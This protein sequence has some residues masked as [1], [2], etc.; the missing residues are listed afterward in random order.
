MLRTDKAKIMRRSIATAVL[1]W[2][3]PGLAHG[4]APSAAQLDA[5]YV[6]SGLAALVAQIP[7]GIQ[8]GFDRYYRQES[9]GS[10]SAPQYK[11]IRERIPR[12]FA[13]EAMRPRIEAVLAERLATADAKT[14]L[15]WFDSPLGR[16]ATALESAAAGPEALEAMQAYARGL[17]QSPPSAE[18]MKRLGALAAA[19]K[20]VDNAVAV[21]MNTQLAV[22]G[23]M[24]AMMPDAQQKSFEEIRARL[25]ALRPQI[26]AAMENQTIIAFLYTYRDL[27]ASDLDAYVRFARSEAG[28]RYHAAAAAGIQQAL[29]AGS[30]ALGSAIAEIIEATEP[31][32]DI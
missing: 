2:L 23:G 10:L 7:A 5:L 26:T 20:A 31:Q 29:T 15:D 12:A 28:E 3:L 13:P 9:G 27:S 24:M 19:V 16:K 32:S 30:L 8:N 4:Q 11:I 6:R 17:R 14:V 22:A 25:E 1:L 18:R 21:V